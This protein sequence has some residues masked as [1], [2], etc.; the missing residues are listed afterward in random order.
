MKTFVLGFILLLIFGISKGQDSIIHRVILIGDAGE[1]N[2]KQTPVI[3]NASDHVLESKTTVLYLGDN[4]YPAG[5]GL[6]GSAEEE[7]TKNILRSQFIPMRAKKASVYFIPGN[8]DWDK[9]GKKGLEK[10]KLQ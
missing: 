7:E 8:H 3:K 5:I 1:I 10:I 2:H 6:P 4:I 9:S